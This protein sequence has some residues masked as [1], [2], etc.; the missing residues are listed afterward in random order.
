MLDEQARLV[1]LFD[2]ATAPPP[3]SSAPRR[4]SPLRARS[5]ARVERAKA[6]LG[7]LDFDDLI[8]KTLALL[9]RGDAAWVL[10]KLDRGIDHV[11]VDEAQDTNPEQW[12]ILRHIT[13]DFT[14]GAGARGSGVRTLFAV[15]DPKQSIYGFQGAAPQRI[16]DR[17]AGVGGHRPRRPSCAS[18]TCG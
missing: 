2:E 14:A 4:S 13:E 17:A 12:E 15:G 5:T 1:G 3:R 9:S 8:D 16:R 7:A 11:L 10:Y 18:K 6:R